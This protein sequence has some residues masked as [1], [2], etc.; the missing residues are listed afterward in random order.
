M[1]S[2][3]DQ[4]SRD[5]L[6]RCVRELS[7]EVAKLRAQGRDGRKLRQVVAD[8][9]I[10][11]E[12]LRAQNETLVSA[13]Q[14]LE[15]SRHRYA[16]LYDFAPVGYV[17]L[18]FNGIIE[19]IN[20]TA[21]GLVG[22]ERANVLRTPLFVYVAESDRQTF[23]E[24]LSRCR[25]QRSALVNS[26]LHLRQ[27]TGRLIPV[28]LSSRY[29]DGERG[30]FRTVIMDLT[31]RQEAEEKRLD[32]VRRQAADHAASQAKDRFLATLSHELRTPLTPVLA[33]VTALEDR[34]D[35]PRDLRQ[36]VQVIRRNVE[37]EAQ[38]VD[39]LLDL[40]RIASGKLRFKSGVVDA[41]A[42]IDEVRQMT[43]AEQRKKDQDVRL[44]LAASAHHVSG[45]ATRLRQVF[46]NL[47]SNAVRFTPIG[48]RITLSTRND[49]P[50][51][52]LIYVRDTG[53]G[54]EPALLE[55]I[56][57]PFEQA[58]QIGGR[59][60]LGLTISRGILEAMGGRIT[61][62]S[63]GAG[64]GATF[65]VRLGTAPAPADQPPAAPAPSTKPRRLR[66]LLVEDHEDTA[67]VLARLL[68]MRGHDV[69]VATSIHSAESILHHEIDPPHLLLS[70][71][72]LPDGSGL[73][74]P[75]RL[76]GAA[77]AKKIVL[78]G[79][80]SDEDVARSRQAGFDEHLTKPIDFR[81]L[82]EVIGRL[83]S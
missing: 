33:E 13:Q 23:L 25:S 26:E 18:D 10:H 76:S 16:D 9:E 83:S 20:L 77:S 80:G 22:L 43:E 71:I 44:D 34:Q 73:E 65:E 52:L 49:G 72:G 66:I 79:Y 62:S 58:G 14:S 53:I 81:H 21:T 28:R 15:Q 27:A 19:E 1:R 39:D 36:T 47:L 5:E 11:Q 63:A 7:S 6:V 69:R 12:E 61:A 78:S 56:F 68:R 50:S 51:E 46:W 41:H 38:L 45:D 4:M 59:L 64:K 74:L 31:E 30:R 32:L 60:G 57:E 3:I 8:L 24:H 40:T 75:A 17:T 2:R 70:D 67:R 55:R 42:V 29:E 48:G 82:L 37:L 35:L 54:I